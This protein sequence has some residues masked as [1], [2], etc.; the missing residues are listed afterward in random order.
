MTLCVHLPRICLSSSSN[1]TSGAT[2]LS[3]EVL[4][5]LTLP[6]HSETVTES[7]SDNDSECG[8]EE[9]NNIL[10]MLGEQSGTVD[11]TGSTS[12]SRPNHRPKRDIYPTI[13]VDFVQNRQNTENNPTRLVLV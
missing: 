5:E 9:D 7:V 11:S 13:P 10:E 8:G 2:L 1:T 4:I 6:G 3:S 12:G